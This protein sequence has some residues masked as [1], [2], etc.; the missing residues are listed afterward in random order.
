MNGYVMKF[1][2]KPYRRIFES[3]DA[4]CLQLALCTII[5]THSANTNGLF[6]VLCVVGKDQHREGGKRRQECNKYEEM[7]A[8]KLGRK[9]NG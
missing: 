3:L 4:F 6:I 2:I 8:E 5:F 7:A 1:G 9:G